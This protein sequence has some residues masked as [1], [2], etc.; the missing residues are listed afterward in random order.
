MPL[1]RTI[2]RLTLA[3][4]LLGSLGACTVAPVYPVGYR[5]APVYV[6]SYPAY[7]SAPPSVY[8]QYEQRYRGNYRQDYYRDDR[9]YDDRRYDNRRPSHSPLEDAARVHRDVRRSLGLPRLPGMP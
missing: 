1:S 5:T 9:R 4:A 8:Y 2:A 3:V 6:E 7:R